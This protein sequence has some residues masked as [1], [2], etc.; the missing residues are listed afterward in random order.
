MWVVSA[1]FTAFL[2]LLGGGLGG[3]ETY[4]L[5]ND[6]TTITAFIRT[7]P[8]YSILAALLFSVVMAFFGYT[9]GV[10]GK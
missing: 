9:L 7:H 1:L 4:A 8:H 5:K 3:W 10:G 6:K 2:V